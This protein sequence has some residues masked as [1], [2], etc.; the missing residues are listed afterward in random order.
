MDRNRIFDIVKICAVPVLMIV[1]GL[2]LLFMPD[3][4]V[5]LVTK[6]AAW[7][8]LI[9]GGAGILG[10]LSGATVRSW[11]SAGLYLLI[12]GYMLANPLTVSNLIG[13][14]FGLVLMVQ[15]FQDLGRSRYGASRVLALVTVAAGVVLLVLPRAL[16]NTVLGFAGLVLIAVGICNLLG[17]FGQVRKLSS[18]SDPNIIDADE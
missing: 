2:V 15:G 4:A 7:I 10:N 13:R 16:T 18:G 5:A 11:I 3:S 17:R 1:L 8:L 12:G 14:I 9:I 6:A